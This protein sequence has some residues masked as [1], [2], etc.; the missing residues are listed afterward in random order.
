VKRS[1]LGTVVTEGALLLL[2]SP[3]FLASQLAA[4]TSG[5]PEV[6]ANPLR[7]APPAQP[8]PYSHKTHLALGIKCTDCHTNPDPGNR[9]SYPAAS[10]CMQ[11]HTTVAKDK[12]SIQKLAQFAASQQPIPWVPVYV[13]L[14]GVQWTHRRHVEAGVK[15]ETCHGAVAQMDAMA[16]TTSVTAMAVCINCHQMHNAK[17]SCGSCH[18][19]PQDA[20]S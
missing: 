8:I 6:P 16:E 17:A 5:K 2:A 14:P 20:K 13:V 15:C 19:W 12:P 3:L 10:T 11:C 1:R 4:Q 7:P 18:Q 9:M